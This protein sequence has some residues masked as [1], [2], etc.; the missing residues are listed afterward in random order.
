MSFTAGTF[1]KRNLLWQQKKCHYSIGERSIIVV[2]KILAPAAIALS[3]NTCCTRHFDTF[4]HKFTPQN[5]PC[6]YWQP[7]SSLVSTLT[8][9]LQSLPSYV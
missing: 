2:K 5:L 3:N 6:L 7:K 8:S 4:Q 1:K 9:L